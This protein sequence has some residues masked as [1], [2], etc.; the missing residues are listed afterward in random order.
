MS[1]ETANTSLVG[2]VTDSATYL[3]LSGASVT[4]TDGAGVTHSETTDSDGRYQVDGMAPGSASIGVSLGGYAS[5]SKSISLT[6]GKI[7]WADFALVSTVIPTPP[8]L[9]PV[10]EPPPVPP[11]A[12]SDEVS[13]ALLAEHD[14]PRTAED[15]PVT[16]TLGI[17]NVYF[18]ADGHVAVAPIHWIE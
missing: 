10:P 7:G 12:H 13:A 4:V 1:D 3:P 17:R 2:T 14:Q 8:P 15:G 6:S 5:A 18:N 16:I 11:K 9:P